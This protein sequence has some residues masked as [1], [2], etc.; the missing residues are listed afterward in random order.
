M[1]WGRNRG[2]MANEH[3]TV[4]GNKYVKVNTI[5]YLD[6]LLINKFIFMRKYNVEL[7][8]VIYVTTELK[9]FYFSHSLE[10]FEN[11]LQ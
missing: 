1:Q 3:I 8:H 10:E 9:W 11:E 2:M 5:K 7:R 4:S 6:P